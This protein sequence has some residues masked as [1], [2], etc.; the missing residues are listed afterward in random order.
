MRKKIL[1]V[2]SFILTIFGI[3]L[4]IVSTTQMLHAIFI[5]SKPG[6][7]DD[8]EKIFIIPGTITLD[9]LSISLAISGISTLHYLKEK[10]N[11]ILCIILNIIG[12]F[13]Y[14]L[15]IY[16]F[17]CLYVFNILKLTIIILLVLICPLMINSI[18][19]YKEKNEI[20]EC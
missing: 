10:N 4:F 7:W 13:L 6:S 11:Y 12:F 5:P 18:L 9:I 14:G 2:N 3:I 15:F 1:K 16:G 8:L 19:L 20:I 17:I